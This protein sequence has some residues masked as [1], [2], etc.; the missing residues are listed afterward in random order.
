MKKEKL[1]GI[2]IFMYGLSILLLLFTIYRFYGAMTYIS[3]LVT[4][5]SFVISENIRDVISYY[6]EQCASPF[7]FSV[8]IYGLGE[9]NEKLKLLLLKKAQPDPESEPNNEQSS[10][11]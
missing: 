10:L 3:S 2:T 1:S 7:L 5:Q 9:M 6:Y 8:I 4:E 11:N